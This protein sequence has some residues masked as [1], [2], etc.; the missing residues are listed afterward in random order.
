M[1]RRLL[2]FFK[3]TP[4]EAFCILILWLFTAVLGAAAAVKFFEG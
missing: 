2:N 3:D 1:L 4:I